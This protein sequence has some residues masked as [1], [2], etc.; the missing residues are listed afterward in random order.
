MI[1]RSSR[2][3]RARFVRSLRRNLR[4]AYRSTRKRAIAN[5][6]SSSRSDNDPRLYY[7]IPVSMSGVE[8][9]SRGAIKSTAPISP[10]I[11]YRWM[12]AREMSRARRLLLSAI[13]PPR[14]SPRALVPAFASLCNYRGEF[15]GGVC[16]L[17][18][19]RP[20]A[21]ISSSTREG[22]AVERFATTEGGGEKV[23]YSYAGARAL[24]IAEGGKGGIHASTAAIDHLIVIEN[25]NRG[26]SIAASAIRSS[27]LQSRGSNLFRDLRS[28]R[29]AK[30][31]DEGRREIY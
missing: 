26:D 19:G 17:H 4:G 16:I 3:R 28:T 2:R 8:V 14:D 9:Q 6:G 12:L 27:Q 22:I 25:R 11:L 5:R 24:S 21:I 30:G 31:R 23:I 18:Y 29:G 7:R 10:R 20:P 15:T 13:I 1:R